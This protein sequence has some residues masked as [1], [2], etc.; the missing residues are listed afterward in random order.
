MKSLLP[1]SAALPEMAAA[2][3][4]LGASWPLTRFALLQGAGP[5]WFALELLP[6]LPILPA[7]AAVLDRPAWPAELEGMLLI[8]AELPAR[9][10]SLLGDAPAFAVRSRVPEAL[11]ALLPSGITVA[12]EPA[13]GLATFAAW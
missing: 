11:E 4:L 13:V 7:W 12:S 9:G 2:V 1:R 8:A 3:L 5:A 10:A 6:A